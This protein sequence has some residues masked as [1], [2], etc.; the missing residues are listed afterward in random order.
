M[1]SLIRHPRGKCYDFAFVLA[2]RQMMLV[3]LIQCSARKSMSQANEM[4]PQSPMNVRD[5][6]T[7]ETADQHR[8]GRP[9]PTRSIKDLLPF[10]MCPPASSDGLAGDSF[11]QR[12]LL[13][14]RRLKHDA[15]ASNK[16]NGQVSRHD[17]RSAA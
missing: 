5:A 7:R 3:D 14:F 15:M 17:L 6:P 4:G 2:T 11:R 12:R 13:S 1:D 8:P 16:T 9:R 10:G